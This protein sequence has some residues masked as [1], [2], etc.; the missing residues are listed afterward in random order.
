MSQTYI[1]LTSSECHQCARARQ[2]LN[3]LSRDLGLVW[4]EVAA[5]SDEGERLAPVAPP[6]RPVLFDQAAHVLAA[7]RLSERRLRR[8]LEPGAARG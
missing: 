4:R 6:L 1:L 8:D 7:G 2:V 3:A 5:D